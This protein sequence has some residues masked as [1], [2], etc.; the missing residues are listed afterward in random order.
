MARCPNCYGEHA[1]VERLSV[2]QILFTCPECHKPTI[3]RFQERRGV[4]WRN[5]LGE[6]G[7]A[8]SGTIE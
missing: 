5:G 1:S 6:K 3:Q 8:F 7:V 4:R 2:G